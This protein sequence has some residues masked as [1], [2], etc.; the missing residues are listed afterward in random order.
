M[1]DKLMVTFADL[2]KLGWPYSRTHTMRLC[3]SGEIPKPRKL[4]NH[5]NAHPIWLWGEIADCLR[6]KGLDVS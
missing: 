3:E 2:K 5:R 6:R 1:V 4:V